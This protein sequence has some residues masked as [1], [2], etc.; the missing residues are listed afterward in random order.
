MIL[1]TKLHAIDQLK[2]LH[3]V[4]NTN[5]EQFWTAEYNESW[6]NIYGLIIHFHL[7]KERDKEGNFFPGKI[8]VITDVYYKEDRK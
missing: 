1:S 6:L 7:N 4:A 5:Y 3:L 2:N 8:R